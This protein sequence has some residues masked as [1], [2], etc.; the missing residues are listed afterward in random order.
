M[1][2]ISR[3]QVL[4]L[5]AAIDERVQTFLRRPIEQP[6]RS[7]ETESPA[8]HAGDWR[9]LSDICL[10]KWRLVRAPP[11]F[12]GVNVQETDRAT[13]GT[14]LLR[15]TTYRAATS[16]ASTAPAAGRRARRP[17]GQCDRRAA[18]LTAW[19]HPNSGRP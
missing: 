9:M 19:V 18:S 11:K 13:E 5:C 12:K 15:C 8:K 2:G 16:F 1:D 7:N 4:R 17:P 6:W 3:S 14:A 10:R